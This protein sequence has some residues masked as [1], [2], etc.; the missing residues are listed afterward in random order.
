MRVGEAAVCCERLV[1]C[2]GLWPARKNHHVCRAAVEVPFVLDVRS[3][4]RYPA[5]DPFDSN[6]T[7]KKGR[8]LDV[9]VTAS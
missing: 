1:A 8:L 6:N 2:G 9:A 5:M 4:L 7:G 3:C